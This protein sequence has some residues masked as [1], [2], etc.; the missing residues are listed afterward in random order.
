[1][2]IETIDQA[3]RWG[4]YLLRLT[5]SDVHSEAVPAIDG[6]Y[7][8]QPI[9]G[10]G[11]LLIDRDGSVL[12]AGSRYALEQM[13]EW[14]LDGGRSVIPSSEYAWLVSAGMVDVAPDEVDEVAGMPRV[15]SARQAAGL[16]ARLL[17]L[18]DGGPEL[19]S[20]EVDEINGFF[21][22]EEARDGVQLLVGRDGSALLGPAPYGLADLMHR[23]R[24]GERTRRAR[25][26]GAAES[27]T[28]DGST[29]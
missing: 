22:W 7:V 2:A 14:F 4:A 25:F 20:R 23:F 11:Q 3:R 24:G 29:A 13:V 17:A 18:P 28:S 12:F 15:E 26:P 9:R 8:C 27:P 19:G 16:A 1:M 10:G 5:P 6:F 21:V